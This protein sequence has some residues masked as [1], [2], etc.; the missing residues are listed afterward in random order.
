VGIAINGIPLFNDVT[1]DNSTQNCS[2]IAHQQFSLVFDDCGGHIDRQ[3]IYH[4]HFLPY[5]VM[6]AVGVNVPANSSYWM[7]M[8]QNGNI[9]DFWPPTSNPSPVIGWALDGFAIMGPY[10]DSGNLVSNQTLDSCGGKIDNDGIYRYYASP[11]PPYLVGCFMGT[12]GSFVDEPIYKACPS[13][14][15]FTKTEESCDVGPMYLFPT[16]L[17]G[18]LWGSFFLFAAISSA[19][20]TL[21]AVFRIAELSYEPVV[22]RR[23]ILMFF[24][25]SWGLSLFVFYFV[26][27]FNQKKRLSPLA[28]NLLYGVQFWAV[29][30]MMG[31][32]V[33]KFFS[34]AVPLG[35]A[36]NFVQ[37]TRSLSARSGNMSHRDSRCYADMKRNVA[38]NMGIF[39]DIVCDRDIILVKVDA[40]NIP[41]TSLQ[42]IPTMAMRATEGKGDESYAA[43]KPKEDVPKEKKLNCTARENATTSVVTMA[44]I[45]NTYK[46]TGFAFRESETDLTAAM[47]NVKNEWF[48]IPFSRLFFLIIF[49][50]IAV[51]TASDVLRAT[52]KDGQDWLFICRIIY[53][54]A[55]MFFLL[56][57]VVCMFR[58]F[59]LRTYL[60]ENSGAVV[61]KFL[62]E[63]S[64]ITAAFFLL[65]ILEVYVRVAL[66]GQDNSSDAG[67]G[68]TI[69][70]FIMQSAGCVLAYIAFKEARVRVLRDRNKVSA[71]VDRLMCAK[72]EDTR[73]KLQKCRMVS[74]VD[75]FAAKSYGSRRNINASFMRVASGGSKPVDIT[76]SETK[77]TFSNTNSSG[78][79]SNPTIPRQV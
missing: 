16:E 62:F 77:P 35:I 3:H 59:R 64:R 33:V 55:G 32:M 49:T 40:E 1:C 70:C 53:L 38:K 61:T 2:S 14:G 50:A 73:L 24:L 12:P 75:L 8:F 34:A 22:D 52:I 27:P 42:N 66:T 31:L 26:D 43:S 72:K 29:D 11:Q 5:C 47:L 28:L 74:Q 45:A 63:G 9:V 46:H 41:V 65:S 79:N 60:P 39:L 58:L 18:N 30:G 6:R 67:E 36:L 37:G 4:Y 44:S 23:L 56:G 15:V 17:S 7:E 20:C 21:L 19:L 57:Y 71:C 51:Q 76:A 25:L 68:Y 69:V 54:G 10:D 13:N 78:N 48:R